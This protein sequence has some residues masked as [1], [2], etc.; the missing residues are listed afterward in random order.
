MKIFSGTA[1]ELLADSICKNLG[2]PLGKINHKTFASGELYC[3][4]LENIRG[5]DVF[6]I[7]PISFP[8]NDNL[9]QLLLMAD[10]ARRASAGKITAVIPYFGYGR[11]DRKDKSRVPISAKLVMDLINASGFDRVVTMDLHAAQVGGF[12]NLP[13]DHLSFKPSLINTIRDNKI[14]IDMIVAPD[15]G[16]VKRTQDY[17]KSLKKNMVIIAKERLNDTEVEVTNFIGNVKNKKVLIVDDLTE[18]VGTLTEAAKACAEKGATEINVA[19]T[20]GC[21]SAKGIVT[22]KEG[23][24]I[25]LFTR[26]FYSN[27]VSTKHYEDSLDEHEESIFNDLSMVCVDVSSVFATAISRIHNNESVSELFVV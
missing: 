22:L 23:I 13:F 2:I 6:L 25:G 8:A 5:S 12:T 27:T 14:D 26:F 17:A 1:N 24:E 21:F 10:A 20:H 9:M 18:S 7:N 3:H 16:A 15:I 19:V 4:F 11:Q